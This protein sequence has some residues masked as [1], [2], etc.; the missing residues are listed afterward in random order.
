MA[1]DVESWL[2]AQFS[3]AGRVVLVTGAS[4]GIGRALAVGF[5]QAGA[6]LILTARDAAALDGTMAEIADLGRTA[7]AIACDQ[8]DVGAI[9]RALGD[10]GPVDVLV[11]NAGTEEVRA[12]LDVDEAL[13]DRIVDTNLKG[14]FFTAQTVAAG[15]AAR[16]ARGA[17]INIASLTSFVGVPTA[18]AYTASKSGIMG[19]TRALAAEWAGL[20]IRVNAIAPGYFRTDLTDVFYQDADWV[21]AMTAKV[22]MGRLGR[23]EDLVGAALFLGGPASAYVTGQSLVVDGGYLATI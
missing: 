9:A 6:D 16:G 18:T 12:S 8:R 1:H 15:M 13:W 21:A 2:S 14:A 22:P 17:I 5:A 20:G 3:F 7:R 19:M 4:R 10:L 23:L 11:N